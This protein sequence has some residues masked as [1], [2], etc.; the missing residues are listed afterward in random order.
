MVK[1]IHTADLHLN[2]PFKGLAH[3]DRDL[4]NQVKAS[5]FDA[6]ARVVD[7]ALDQEVDFVLIAGDLFDL[8]SRSIYAQ[9]FLKDQFTRLQ[10]AGIPV[11]IGF[12]NHDYVADQRFYLDFPDNVTIFPDQVTTHYLESKAGEKVAITGFSYHQQHIAKNMLASFPARDK[13]VD[14]HLGLYHGDLASQSQDYAPF[15]KEDIARLHYHYLALGHIHFFHQVFPDLPAYYPGNTQG[16][17]INEKGQKGALLV[18][19]QGP[20]HQ[21]S[22]FPTASLEWDEWDLPVTDQDTINSVHQ[23]LLDRLAGKKTYQIIRVNFLVHDQAGK[24]LADQLSA[25]KLNEL[26]LDQ[27]LWLKD[28]KIIWQAK[29]DKLAS[30]YPRAWQEAVTSLKRTGL[31][32]YLNI[33]KQKIDESYL[34]DLESSSRQADLV[35]Q[36][37]QLLDQEDKG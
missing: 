1:F 37:K 6:F 12:G 33:L 15:Q 19:L 9:V 11:F 23:A 20:N 29:Q 32:G 5:T 8:A 13:Q 21:V 35:D 31:D 36:A 30:L 2:S 34:K 3:M 27:D 10:E 17:H 4:L 24:D 16:R 25:D 28:R 7:Q 18:T 14:Y 26:V 22:F